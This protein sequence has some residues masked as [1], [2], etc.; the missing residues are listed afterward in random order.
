MN[1]MDRGDDELEVPFIFVPHGDPEPTAWMAEHP[2]WVK[3]PARF[4][5]HAAPERADEPIRVAAIGSTAVRTATIWE[6]GT[7]ADRGFALLGES[8][9]VAALAAGAVGLLAYGLRISPTGGGAA[10]EA[11]R[12][13]YLDEQER[14]VRE[15]FSPSPPLPP[16]P[17]SVPPHVPGD[18]PGEGGFTAHPEAKPEPGSVPPVMPPWFLPGEMPQEQAVIIA[19]NQRNDGL[20]TEQKT[21]SWRA[22]KTLEQAGDKATKLL[23]APDWVGH[24]LID[25]DNIRKN[26]GLFGAAAQAGWRTDEAGN[27]VALPSNEAARGTL[28]E[29][30][31]ERPVQRGPHPGLSGDVS[32]RLDR[33]QTELDGAGLEKGTDAYNQ[34]ARKLIER[35]QNELREDLKKYMKLTEGEAGEGG[36]VG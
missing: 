25:V 22:R 19:E 15:G 35:L 18:R 31:I 32:R 23:E 1:R 36:N 10:D 20:P 5:P 9:P 7:W 21:Y 28:R 4:V 30:G 12:R 14:Q 29:H 16:V 3:F 8:G 6:A 13:R 27:V 26:P 2:G 33:L 17:G 34:A 11:L 24:H